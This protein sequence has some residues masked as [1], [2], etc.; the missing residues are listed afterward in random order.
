MKVEA[1]VAL[2]FLIK[3]QST[4][5]SFIKPHVKPIIEVQMYVCETVQVQIDMSLSLL[6]I[7]A[8]SVPGEC[9]M[10]VFF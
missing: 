3:N 9:A 1:A 7:M 8:I 5:E 4:A 2:Q 10:S 6:I